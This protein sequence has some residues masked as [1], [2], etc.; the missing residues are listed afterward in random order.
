[1]IGRPDYIA[2]VT[3]LLILHRLRKPDNIKRD[4]EGFVTR[5]ELMKTIGCSYPTVAGALQRL[6]RSITQRSD[7]SVALNRFPEKTWAEIVLASERSRQTLRFA[8]R[9]GQARSPSSL[10]RRLNDLD[11]PPLGLAGTLG[12]QHWYPDL[13]LHGDPRIDLSM[14][15]PRDRMDLNFVEKLDRALKREEDPTAPAS[16]VIHAIRRKE[17]YFTESDEGLSIADPVECMLDLHE[18][19]LEPQ[20]DSLYRFLERGEDDR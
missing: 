20:A 11:T 6:G 9:S 19:R 14:H 17:A 18:L 13:D 7:R 3:K 15:C 16:L 1:M 2:E 12:T 8:D 4:S 10:L 5:T